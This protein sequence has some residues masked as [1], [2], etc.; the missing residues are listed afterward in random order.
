MPDAEIIQLGSRGPA[1]R[2]SRKAPSAAARGLVAD[3]PTP[4]RRPPQGRRRPDRWRS[5]STSRSRASR[6]SRWSP[7][8]SSREPETLDAVAVEDERRRGPGRPGPTTAR[9]VRSRRRWTWRPCWPNCWTSSPGPAE[10]L[11]NLPADQRCATWS[12]TRCAPPSALAERLGVDWSTSVEQLATF[13]RSRLSGDY[14]DRRVR[15]RPASSPQGSSCRCCARWSQSWFRV[16]VR[17]AENLPTT[18]S[19]L[20]VSNHAG[21]HAAG[22]HGAALGGLRRDRPARPDARRGPDLQDP[23]RRTTS[24]ARPAPPWPARRTPNGCWPASSSS[25]S[26]PEGF[27]GLGKPYAR[28]LQAA[29]LR[30]RRVRLG[31]RP[32]AGADHPGLDRRLGGDLPAA[33]RPRPTLARAHG[34]AVLPGDADCSRGSACSG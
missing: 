17:G 9:P 7:S 5:P 23:V 34:G 14:A 30:P 24:P 29:A 13:V 27:K 33:R 4:R 22:R 3:R 10:F 26:I 1:G 12:T 21:T 15:L 32:G 6:P 25:P 31:G 16:E 20:L 11:Q 2:G 18:G 8:P 19:A 28:S